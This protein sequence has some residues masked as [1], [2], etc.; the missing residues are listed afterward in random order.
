MRIAF[1][2][3]ARKTGS[4]S[5]GE[6]EITFSTS[7]VAVCCSSN[8]VRS[9][10]RWRNSL[11]SRVFS[12][13]MTACAA[14]VLQHC[15][16]LVGERPGHKPHDAEQAD[17][18][19]A[20]H[21]GHDRDR[22]VAA[23]QEVLGPGDKFRR[24][25]RHVGNIH[26]PA[27]KQGCAVHVIPREG[28][29]GNCA[30]PR[31]DA[32]RIRRGDGRGVDR[33]PIPE[34]DAD[35]G[36]RKELQPALHD[37]V[38]HR[39][40]IGGRV[41]DDVQNLG[42]RRLLLQRLGQIVGALAQLVEQPRVFDRD[43]GLIGERLE[44]RDVLVLERTHLGAADQDRAQCATFADQRHGEDRPM[45]VIAR[46]LPGKCKFIAG[47]QRVGYVN[48][49]LVVD[50]TPHDRGTVEQVRLANR[51]AELAECR[52]DPKLPVVNDQDAHDL[53]VAN[54]SGM[55]GNHIQHR[56]HVARRARRSR[57]GCR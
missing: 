6:L 39:L 36:A 3:T 17:R 14:K 57:A 22:A 5:P 42:S 30:S 16:L 56:F 19:I 48:R 40:G 34:R 28:G 7:L 41:A 55:L 54:A 37:G 47:I 49:P 43:R 8:S 50:R 25:I 12:I 32:S 52:P 53:R 4:S 29:T 31:F 18:L 23:G 26:D 27:I 10:V 1:A 2:S 24:G 13:A 45:P 51:P 33:V 38:E 46:I 11:S 20:A 35:E 9:S 44:Q 21:H 15:D